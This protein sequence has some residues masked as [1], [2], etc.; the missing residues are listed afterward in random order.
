MQPES[1]AMLSKTE[2]EI[3]ALLRAMDF[4]ELR[5]VIQDGRPIRI[6]EIRRSIKLSK[7]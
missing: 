1:G 7:N 3:L 4:G 5:V 2:E 6:E